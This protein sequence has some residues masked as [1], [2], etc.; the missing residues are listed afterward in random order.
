MED[1]QEHNKENR[2]KES[3]PDSTF[4]SDVSNSVGTRIKQA[5][6]NETVK[7]FSRRC[8]VADTSLRDYIGGKKKPGLDAITAISEYA[9]VTVDWLATG[10]GIKYTKDLKHAEERLRGSPP[11]VLPELPPE[12]EPY[13]K[14][15]DALLIYLS[16]IE[17]AEERSQIIDSFVLRAQDQIDLAPIK[18][19]FTKNKAG[20]QKK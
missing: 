7:A 16:M 4:F 11:A 8:G 20:N 15:L 1:K 14:R 17:D 10:K 19:Y 5:I 2:G 12:L 13:R 6:G 3:A 9:G 18:D